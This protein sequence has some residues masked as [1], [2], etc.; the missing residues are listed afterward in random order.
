MRLLFCILILLSGCR[1]K[2]SVEVSTTPPPAA[3][4]T[5]PEDAYE[6]PASNYDYAELF[7]VYDHESTTK[8]FSAVLS[9][10]QNGNDLYFSASVAQ[11]SCTGETEG[12]VLMLEQNQNYFSGFYESDDC[13][14]QFTFIPAEKKVDIKE[15]SICRLLEGGC[16][17]EGTYLKRNV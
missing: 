10:R 12:V 5:T 7:G 13:R 11:A 17:F 14:L 15:V 1:Q 6:K 16:S 8:G 2:Q 9:L 3:K 4:E